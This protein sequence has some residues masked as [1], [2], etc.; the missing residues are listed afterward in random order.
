MSSYKKIICKGTLRLVF[1]LSEAPSP[2]MTPFPPYTLYMCILYTYLHRKGG[3]ELTREKVREVTVEN[4][5]MTDCITSLY[6]NSANICRK[7]L[8]QVNF[9]R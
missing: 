4:T 1:Y 7:V 2:P 3:G 5:N 9:F 6:I 8:L